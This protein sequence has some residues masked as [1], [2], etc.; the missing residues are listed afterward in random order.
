MTR[1]TRITRFRYDE[2]SD[3]LYPI[4]SNRPVT[5][6]RKGRVI[7]A[8]SNLRP[9][10]NMVET[11]MPLNNN[12]IER[13]EGFKI[14]WTPMAWITGAVVAMIGAVGFSVPI[15]SLTML[16]L[17]GLGFAFFEHFSLLTYFCH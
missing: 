4:D 5:T 2:D 17:F 13:A 16:L 11:Q 9:L 3:H 12:Y 15:V 10:S 1:E 14:A 6:P 7:D 8:T